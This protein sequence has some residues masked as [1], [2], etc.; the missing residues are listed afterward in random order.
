MRLI[1]TTSLILAEFQEETAPVYAILS[2]TWGTRE[3]EV[4]FQQMTNRTPAVEAKSGYAK[5]RRFC[6]VASSKYMVDW[7]WVD[8]CCIDKSSSAELSEA[9]NSMYRWYEKASVCVTFLADYPSHVEVFTESA[10]F[11]RGWTLQEL[12]SPRQLE[13][14]DSHWQ[15]LGTKFDLVDQLATRTGIPSSILRKEKEVSEIPVAERMYWVSSRQITRGEDIAYCLL[16]IFD[17]NMPML[18]GEGGTKA[19]LRLQEEIIKQDTDMSIFAWTAHV[20][21]EIDEDFSGLLATSPK[22]FSC[23]RLEPGIHVPCHQST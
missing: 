22:C 23:G 11:T 4:T 10:W 16:G 17:I 2:H 8:T 19:F 1:N 21:S 15:L 6:E 5:I 12:I 18:Y 13:F 14:W 7:A 3:E 9:I 20:T